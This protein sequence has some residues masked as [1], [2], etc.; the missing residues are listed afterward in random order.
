[1]R[2]DEWMTLGLFERSLVFSRRRLSIAQN[3]SLPS[4]PRRLVAVLFL[5][6]S[7]LHVHASASPQ[8]DGRDYCRL[9]RRHG[10]LFRE[11]RKA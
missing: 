3:M 11:V 9:A 6:A 8:T 2:C 4:L 5:L 1:M 10:C 7:A